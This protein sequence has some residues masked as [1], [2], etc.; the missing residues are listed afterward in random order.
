MSRYCKQCGAPLTEEARFCRRCGA[1][2]GALAPAATSDSSAPTLALPPTGPITDADPE[3]VAP[4]IPLSPTEP[5][6]Q[7]GQEHVAP[8]A[9]LAQTELMTQRLPEATAAGLPQ[10]KDQPAKSRRSLMLAG[11]VAGLVIVAGVSFYVGSLRPSEES[12]SVSQPP[13]ASQ[14]SATANQSPSS[15]TLTLNKTSDVEVKPSGSTKAAKG[16]GS[17][18]G[19]APKTRAKTVSAEH[20]LKQGTEYL[21]AKRYQEAL[22]EYEQV[23]RLEPANKDVYYLIGQAHHQSGQLE[24]ALQAYQQCT[25]GTYAALAQQHVKKLEKKLGRSK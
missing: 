20:H 11:V 24:L 5:Q 12:P 9:P 19:A 16:G 15:P 7:A 23:R 21:S 14:P 18:S 4:T 10:P 25:S 13:D 6:A 2:T 17:A 1:A 22:R 8:T 3:G